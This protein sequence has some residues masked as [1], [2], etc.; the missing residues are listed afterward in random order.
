MRVLVIEDNLKLANLIRKGLAERHYVTDVCHDGEDGLHLAVTEPY[1]LV[2]LDLMLPKRDG[3]EILQTLRQKRVNTPVLILTAKDSVDDKIRGLD[4][5]A[6]EYIAK[7]FVFG[8]LMARIRAL[9]RRA[10][11]VELSKLTVGD[12]VLDLDRHAASRGGQ[13]IGLSPKEF[14]LLR[15]FMQNVDRILTRTSI[16]EHVWDMN[17]S[18]F[19]NVIDV[20]VNYLRN[21]IDR[22]FDAPLIHTVRGVGYVMRTPQ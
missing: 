9:L 4:L 10:R 19:S 1:D 2:I 12:L 20:H 5:G 11:G 21:K 13:P 16:A 3:I 18:G 17:F 22:G 7:P 8:E 6:D 15:Y 14:L